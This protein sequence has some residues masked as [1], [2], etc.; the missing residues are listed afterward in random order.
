MRG[1]EQRA[2]TGIY[3]RATR[4]RPNN[5]YRVLCIHARSGAAL[6][7]QRGGAA[8]AVR[9][10]SAHGVPS[11]LCV[12]LAGAGVGE[13]WSLALQKS[14]LFAPQPQTWLN[15]TKSLWTASGF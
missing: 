1:P 5:I 15:Q 14:P 4:G 2:D 11:A 3:G 8:C 9:L 13:E 6:G 7:L 12:R 10:W